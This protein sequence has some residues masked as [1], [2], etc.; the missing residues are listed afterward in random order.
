MKVII[1]GALGHIGSKLIRTFQKKFEN[2]ELVMVDDLST[3]RYC[4]LFNLPKE[5]RYTFIEKKVSDVDW[6]NVLKSADVTIHLAAL[7]DATG[8]ADRPQLVHD[9]NFESTKVLADS[10]LKE[11]VPIIFPSSTSVYGSQAELVDEDCQ[12]LQ[13]QSPYAACKIKEEQYLKNLFKSGL[14]GTIFRLGTIYGISPGMRFHTAVN[15]FCWQSVMNQPIT[16]WETA[17]NQKRPY[18]SLG[19][20]CRSIVWLIQ[21]KLYSGEIFNIVTNNCTVEEVL[22]IIQKFVS[23]TEIQFVKHKIMNQLSYEVDAEKIKKTGFY[24][25]GKLEKEIEETIQLLKQS[26]MH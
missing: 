13:P 1:T 18:L 7:T 21:N 11:G 3:Q 15:K 6:G 12:Y 2:I 25:K 4:S 19:D 24:F 8:T 17:F 10:C 22:V 16:V 5:V 23:N 14:K 20:C 26:S 9:N